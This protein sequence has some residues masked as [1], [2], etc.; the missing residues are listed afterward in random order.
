MADTSDE[1]SDMVTVEVRRDEA[2]YLASERCSCGHLYSLHN[3]HCCS[4]C[5]VGDCPCEI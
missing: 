5:L 4:F 3:L 1:A 2:A